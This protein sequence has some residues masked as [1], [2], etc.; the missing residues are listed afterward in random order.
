VKELLL[1]LL[2][3]AAAAGFVALFDRASRRRG[4]D[5][6]G[7]R[8]PARRL[9]GLSALALVLALTAFAPLAGLGQPE[10]PPRSFEGVAPWQLFVI[11]VLL[12]ATMVIWWTAA[13]GGSGERPGRQ[14]GLAARRPGVELALG[15]AFGVA[16]WLVV[17]VGAAL[18]AGTIAALGGEDL[19]PK[20]P[21]TAISWLAGQTLALRAALALS[22]GVVEEAF[23][24]G[25]LQPRIGIAASTAVF[26]LAHLAYGQPFLLVGITI[27]SVLYGLL[28]R[29]R[30]SIWAAIAAH[31]VFDLVQLL[32]VV[33]A[34]LKEFRGF[35]AS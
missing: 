22:A 5:P 12:V 10:P 20:G 18:V 31:A 24:R 29:W 30:Q 2:P 9:L 14:L 25:L 32:I 35:F 11:H 15:V 3:F 19:L 23:F 6:P 27:L 26:A 21:P 16:A 4:L 13:Y 17:L 33:P 8:Q 7:F 28:V 34:V 1:G